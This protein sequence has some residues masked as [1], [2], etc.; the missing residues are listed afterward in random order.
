MHLYLIKLLCTFVIQHSYLQQCQ[1]STFYTL[2]SRVYSLQSIVYSLQ[3][4]VYIIYLEAGIRELDSVKCLLYLPLHDL[5]GSWYR[6]AGWCEMSE[7][8]RCRPR[9][10]GQ[11]PAA[12]Q[13]FLKTEIFYNFYHCKS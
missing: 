1:H 12:G 3:S 7:C 6:R 11:H 2:H 5:S 13:S 9:Y 4:I 10:S 8:L